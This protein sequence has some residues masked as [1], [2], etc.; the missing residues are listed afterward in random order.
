VRAQ[1]GTTN[2]LPGLHSTCRSPFEKLSRSD[3]CARSLAHVDPDEA[4]LQADEPALSKICLLT[5]DAGKSGEALHDYP[6]LPGLVWA[7][8]YV[9][10]PYTWGFVMERDDTKEVV[11]Y[12]LGATDTRA[13][14]KAAKET[15]WPSLRPKYPAEGELK[16]VGKPADER[17]AKLISNMDPIEQESVDFSPAH[18]HI[19]IL[20]EYQKKG[21][22]KKLIGRGVEY[23]RD[24]AGLDGVFLGMDMRNVDARRF[25][26]RL[27]FRRWSGAP[28][29][30]V[31][32][33]FS[34][35]RY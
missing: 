23:L 12:I 33:K 19:D 5:S 32:L 20:E 15:W 22:G 8:P 31:G 7:V 35:W 6:E 16:I 24:E 4:A 13:F 34:D 26:E 18:F 29:H 11:G 2:P 27:G 14:E 17:Y 1:S 10:L 30:S 28:E 3:N 9:K 21:W 25:Y